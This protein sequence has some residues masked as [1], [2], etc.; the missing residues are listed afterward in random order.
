[1]VECQL[2]KLD[3]AG[4]TPVSRSISF[5]CFMALFLAFRA[6]KFTLLKRPI[7]G[8]KR[9]ITR[10]KPFISEGMQTLNASRLL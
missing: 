1:M 3:V 9:S 4:S 7:N 8:V 5:Q 2:P 10:H 6:A